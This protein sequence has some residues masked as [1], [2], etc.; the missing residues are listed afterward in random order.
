MR[1]LIKHANAHSHT[2]VRLCVQKMLDRNHITAWN[3]IQSV[4]STTVLLLAVYEVN[5]VILL[6]ALN[7]HLAVSS[8]AMKRYC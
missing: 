4:L 1:L 6:W 8:D 7:K 3:E 2:R 5:P